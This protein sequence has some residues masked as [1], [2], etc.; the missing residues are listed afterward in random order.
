MLA[1]VAALVGVFTLL[2]ISELLGRRKKLRGDPQRQFVHITVGSFIAFWPWIM[3]WSAIVWLGVAML[4]VAFI[5]QRLKIIDFHSRLNR[6]TNG[7]I[8]YALSIICSA[9]ITHQK[10]FFAI[11]ILIMA[12][13]DGL[14]N[15]VGQ[16]YGRNWQY[17]VF[18]QTKS[19]IGSMTMWF[20]SLI[21]LG[22]GLL[23]AH[24]TIDFSNYVVLLII[25]PPIITAAEN[26]S[27]AGVDNLI[28][29]LVTLAVLNLAR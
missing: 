28:L 18:H 16:R 11:A 4:L 29:P 2:V 21:I 24:N 9:L 17:R 15:V 27:V 5:N 3:S 6:D 10:V 22:A 26:I 20:S 19:V 25:L 13:G 7:H 1:I 8:F 14:A 23:F 12:I